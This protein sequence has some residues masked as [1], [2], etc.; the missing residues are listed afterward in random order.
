MLLTF[1]LSFFFLAMWRLHRFPLHYQ[2]P[3]IVRLPYHLFGENE[4]RTYDD[5]GIAGAA[6]RAAEQRTKL[7]RYFALCIRDPPHPPISYVLLPTRYRWTSPGE[8]LP[9]DWILRVNKTQVIGRLHLAYPHQGELSYLRMLLKISKIASGF[10]FLRTYRD[11][12]FPSFRDACIARD[13]LQDDEE[14]FG[15]IQEAAL[16]ENG[17][18]LRLL[19]CRI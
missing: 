19:L 2:F 13:L 7:L 6:E 3:N 11:Q 14:W 9:S 12:V 5:E 17:H 4:V 15:C 1:L 8:G 16:F 10:E 18:H